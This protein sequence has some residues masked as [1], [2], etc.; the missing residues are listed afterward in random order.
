[1]SGCV[2]VAWELPAVD[3]VGAD[4][5]LSG[6]GRAGGYGNRACSESVPAPG[7]VVLSAY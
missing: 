4:V 1:M 7:A 3:G 2:N 6:A 5:G